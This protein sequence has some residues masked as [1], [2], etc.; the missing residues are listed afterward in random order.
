LLS[1]QHLPVKIQPEMPSVE[2]TIRPLVESDLNEWLRLRRLL[3][4]QAAEDDH[5][6]EM[7]DIFE[8]PDSQLVVV[9]D[10]GDGDLAAF[11]E[12]S[13]RPIAEDCETDNVGYL[14]GWYVEEDS[15][16]SGLGRA[17]VDYAEKWARGRGCREMASDAEVGNDVSLAAHQALGYGV[18]SRLVHLR[19]EL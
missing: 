15:R 9:A 1:H 8:H 6:E 11:L 13:I 16:R 12:A 14:E 17:L 4:D 19:K 2:Y 7:V 10:R 3:W 5:R 18:T